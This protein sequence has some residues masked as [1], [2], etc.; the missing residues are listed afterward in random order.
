M[1]HNV[2]QDC[3]SQSYF[4]NFQGRQ[5]NK[6]RVHLVSSPTLTPA[7]QSHLEQYVANL[8]KIIQDQIKASQKETKN[9]KCYNR[10]AGFTSAN[11]CCFNLR[12]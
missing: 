6:V 2:Q 8:E 3:L 5:E 11:I 10:G 12:A 7:W 4:G 9:S 1:H